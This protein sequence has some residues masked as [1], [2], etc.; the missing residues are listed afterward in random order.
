MF[1]IF[2][3]L[4]TS[5]I[6]ILIIM[7]L[8]ICQA[9]LDLALPDYTSKI[10]NIG[11]QQN[12]IENAALEVISESTFNEISILVDF[13]ELE[14]LK[15]NYKLIKKGNSKYIKEYPILKDENVYLLN[16]KK[17]D[18]ID[19]ILT[20]AFSL[21]Y[22]SDMLTKME[23][24]SFNIP[25]GMNLID[26]L[27]N[28]DETTKEETI[29]KLE[30]ILSNMPDTILNSSAIE[31]VKNEYE[32]VG[33]NLGKMQTNYIITSGAKMLGIALLIMLVAIG[34]TFFG[35]R[36]AAKLAYTL[37]SKV[38]EKIVHFSKSEIKKFG[39]A[40]LITRTTNDIQQIQQVVVFLMRIVF[41]AP[42]IA[43]GGILKT[44]SA[45]K[46][47][48]WIIVLAVITLFIILGTLFIVTLPKFTKL[49]VLIDKL[50]LVARETLS[51]IP[52][53][54]AFSN[55]KHEEER[56][57][58]ANKTLTK[59]NLFV[60][61][62][63]ALMM[64]LMMLLMNVVCIAIVWYGAVGVDSGTIQVGDILAYIQYSM[65]IIMAFL[66]ISMVSIMLPR[67]NVSAKRIVEI[68]ETKDTIID[69]KEEQEFDET[70][71]GL[72]EFKN[73]CFRYPDASEDIIT[74]VNFKALP[75]T[76]TAL[77]GSTGSGKSTLINLIPRFFDVTE[78]S[79][80]I[81]GVDIRN[82]NQE[83]LRNKIGY[84]PQKGI[85]FS[86]NIESNV[87]YGNKSVTFKQMEE[88]AKIAQATDFIEAKPK[89]YKESIAQGG[90]NVSGGQRQRLAIARALATNPDILIFDDSFSAL[91]FKTD[92]KLRKELSKVTKDKTVFIVA[93]RI[94]TIMNAEQIIVLNE[95]KVVGIGTHKEL[96]KSCEVYREI[97]L[98]QIGEEEINNG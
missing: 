85:L 24:N 71:K 19:E 33:I 91:D 98:S 77:I 44:T 49:Q 88:A 70:K 96:V 2:K 25:A 10:I 80:L 82:I 67:A 83:T 48:L 7:G 40:S 27:T 1:K 95:G 55:E 46:S 17:I 89:K 81:D 39:T 47:M 15:E 32:K 74:D 37:R 84:V 23:N 59:V 30:D 62:T 8:L 21:F 29:K 61:R 28:M 54:R 53:I 50:N 97:A 34:V 68:L 78:G 66:M 65:Q 72:V 86:G 76:T 45:D 57:D 14:Y 26:M 73:V 11:I 38:F 18:K 87:K 79:I 58:K 20:N 3:Y 16:T 60:N 51:G 56:F 94:S 9:N 64:P 35:S 6:S 4:K 52:V 93:Q 31:F 90:T 75:G 36:L 13:E 63:M 22:V 43:I 12:G 41:Y 5:I 69:P 42:I 92:A